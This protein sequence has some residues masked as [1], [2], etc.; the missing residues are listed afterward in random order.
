MGNFDRD[1]SCALAG[2]FQAAYLAQQLARGGKSDNAAFRGS[3]HSVLRIDADNTEA[4]YGGVSGIVLGLQILRD[5]LS[6]TRNPLDLEL[7]RYVISMMQLERAL[8]KRPELLE[9]IARG[10]ESAKAQMGFFDRGENETVHPALVEKLAELYA[11]NISILT[12]RIIISGEQGHLSNSLIAAKVRS[13]LL[14]GIRSA[15]LW[16]QLGG[17]RWQ[18]IFGRRHIASQANQLLISP[19]APRLLH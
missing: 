19:S 3:I 13:A 10:I 5:K 1:R 7:A 2:I 9:T 11:Q 16:R 17:T 4:V 8:S 6:G 18:L 12:P 15:V 14:A